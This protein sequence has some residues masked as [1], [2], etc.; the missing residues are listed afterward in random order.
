MAQLRIQRKKSGGGGDCLQVIF[1][2]SQTYTIES[3]WK[4]M[5]VFLVGGAGPA[6][7]GS[8]S[9]S[10]TLNLNIRGGNGGQGG[11]TK[12]FRLVN[13]SQNKNITITIGSGAG[14]SP[15]LLNFDETEIEFKALGGENTS[16]GSLYGNGAYRDPYSAGNATNGRSDGAEGQ[17]RTTT[18]FEEN[19]GYK[20]SA[21]GGG[22]GFSYTISGGSGSRG[23]SSG[24][25]DGAGSGSPDISSSGRSASANSGSGGGGGFARNNRGSGSSTGGGYG[26]SGIAMI[27]L[28]RNNDRPT[29]IDWSDKTINL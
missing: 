5:D 13:C 1:K 25:A 26:G 22:G 20:Y 17:R 18:A 23:N 3:K 12:T 7:S 9:G 27:R 4:S 8:S 24:G 14:N 16:V 2:S 6:R 11:E 19:I 29:N 15:T 21:G 28:Y 10:T